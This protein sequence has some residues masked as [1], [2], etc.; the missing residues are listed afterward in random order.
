MP[1]NDSVCTDTLVLPGLWMKTAI[2]FFKRDVNV[3]HEWGMEK[4]FFYPISKQP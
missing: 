4:N 1:P 2:A 3:T